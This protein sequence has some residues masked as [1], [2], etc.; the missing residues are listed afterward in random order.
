ML[1]VESLH[2]LI[3]GT[4]RELFIRIFYKR[5]SCRKRGNK[6]R[7]ER[8]IRWMCG[9]FPP[10]KV[11]LIAALDLFPIFVRRATHKERKK[12]RRSTSSCCCC[13][14]FFLCYAQEGPTRA[15]RE[16]YRKW[17]Q[18]APKKSRRQ[19]DKTYLPPCPALAGFVALTESYFT[20]YLRPA[21]KALARVFQKL[22]P[23]K[24][25]SESDGG[26]LRS[27]KKDADTTAMR[28]KEEIRRAS[29]QQQTG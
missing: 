16:L 22:L 20:Q 15:A 25:K 9:G 18:R 19:L 6:A 10:D 11:L 21:S 14:F 2:S 13:F 1:V 4:Q 24:N 12:E 29:R 28:C 7:R 8:P 27:N 26:S 23:H 5:G 3:H 17:P